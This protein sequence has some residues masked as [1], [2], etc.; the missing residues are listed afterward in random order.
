[1]SIF[2]VTP[3]DSETFTIVTNPSRHYTSSSTGGSTGSV[4][5]FAR[6]SVIEKETSPLSSFIEATKD[7][8]DL[9]ILQAQLSATGK[10][11]RN[12]P[13]I[14]LANPE[15]FNSM[16][17]SYLTGVNKQGISA[18]KQKALEIIRFT[19][20]FNFTSNTMRKL[21][22]KDNLNSYYRCSY[23][24]AHW[25]YS[26]YNCLNFFTSSTVPSSSVLLYPNVE[27]PPITAHE[28]YVTGAYSLSG[29]FSFDFYINPRYTSDSPDGSFHAGTLFHL[30]SSYALSLITGSSKDH[31]GYPV[32]FRLQLQLSHSADLSPSLATTNTGSQS[33]LVFLSADNSLWQNRWHHV[34]VRWGTN[35]VND[36]TGSFNIDGKDFGT[37]VIQSGTVAPLLFGQPPKVL[38]IGNYYEG[39]DDMRQFFAA[40]PALRDGLVELDSTTSVEAPTG[41]SFNHPLNAEIHDLAIKRY[42]MTDADIT[43]S[44]S[45]GPKSTDDSIAFYLPPF[46]VEDSPFRKFVGDVGGILQT[47]FFEVDGT[48]DDP[49]NV[50]L[51]F[52][53][54]GHYINIENF[55]RDFASNVF[56]RVHHMTGVAIMNTSQLR[57]ANDFLYDQPYVVRRNTL[58]MPCD[59]GLFVPSFEL[60]ASES[61]R[62]RAIDDLGTEELSFINLDNMVKTSSLLFGTSFDA[63]DK[64]ES[65]ENDFVNES[66]GFTPE[67]PGLAPGRAF[68]LHANRVDQSITSGTFDA[69]IQDFAPLTIFNRTRDPSSNQVTFF[70]ISNLYYGNKILPGSFEIKDPNLSSSGGVIGITLR[71]D[72][73]GNI[74]RADCLTSQSTWNSVGNIYYDE[75]IVVIKSPHLYF[76][77]KNEFEVSFK[78]EQNVHVLKFDILAP[79][80]VL[81]S[82]SNPNFVSVP[83][84]AFP[85]DPD[86][87][88]VY[89]T[90]M[91]FHD[92]NYNVVMKAQLAQPIMKRTGDRLMFRIKYDF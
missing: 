72:S 52:G 68:S 90:G 71:D 70:D 19:P 1:M 38:A 12:S 3:N 31:N 25:A 13:A 58:I 87:E 61:N 77:G 28:G 78:G 15:M 22:V 30:S 24:S 69:G 39:W 57:S 56:P 26:N 40:D 4:N 85:N 80:N 11:I 29:A 6:R 75:G 83:P 73:H 23:P 48:T 64:N 50:A 2:K 53:V 89:I 67:Q 88:F 14:E 82:S 16:L 91:N 32:G 36:G 86:S 43:Y 81:N 46:F 18:R 63:E 49:F 9:N 42:Y 92:D 5:V 60:L 55:L 65:D 8:S 17:V 74:Y 45:I 59:D 54:A 10:A 34:V 20:S 27:G 51:S 84:S 37:F 21:I 41:Y 44:A 33:D 66:I 76:Y 47:P 35:L 62:D 79:A 7:D